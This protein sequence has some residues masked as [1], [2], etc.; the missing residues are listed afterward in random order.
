MERVNNIQEKINNI[1]REME[2]LWK[3]RKKMTEIENT[4]REMK[5]ALMCSSV[6]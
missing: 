1:G 6:D 2:I 4:V 3:N 5:N